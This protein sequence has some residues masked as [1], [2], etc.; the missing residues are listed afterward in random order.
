[1]IGGGASG[2]SGSSVVQEPLF[3]PTMCAVGHRAPRRSRMAAY[4]R[5]GRRAAPLTR[6]GASSLRRP[7]ALSGPGGAGS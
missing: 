5:R 3:V 1:V 7:S 6:V 4:V 2:F